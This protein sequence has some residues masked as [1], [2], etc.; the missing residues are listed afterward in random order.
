MYRSNSNI[1][2]PWL[3]Q[4]V[5]EGKPTY[6]HSGAYLPPLFFSKISSF[7]SD[8]RQPARLKKDFGVDEKTT[9][10]ILPPLLSGPDKF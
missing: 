5:F 2:T 8:E 7:F 6:I 4:A 9:P 1:I 10:E 3:N